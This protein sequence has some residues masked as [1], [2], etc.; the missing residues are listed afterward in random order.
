MLP[1]FIIYYETRHI[2]LNAHCTGY[3]AHS[4]VKVLARF[5]SSPKPLKPSSE[6]CWSD[7]CNVDSDIHD[8]KY[9]TET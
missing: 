7:T 9:Q 8:H 5:R 3:T 6:I 1:K 4:F 2:A